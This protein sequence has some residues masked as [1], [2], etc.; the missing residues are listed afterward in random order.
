M[1]Y[2]FAKAPLVPTPV[3]CNIHPWMKGYIVA[4]DNPYTAVSKPDGTLRDQGFAGRRELEFQAWHEKSGYLATA[5]WG[6]R[7]M[8]KYTI[9]D[10]DN[11]LGTIKLSP[12]LFNK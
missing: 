5:D 11:D 7:G 4:K 2:N 1:T 6:K 12:E 10:G 9:K 3:T 8:F